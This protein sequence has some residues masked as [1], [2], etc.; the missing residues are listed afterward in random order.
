MNSKKSFLLGVLLCA[1]PLIAENLKIALLEPRVGEGSDSIAGIELSIIQGELR[2]SIVSFEGYDAITRSDINQ[3]MREQNFQR[4]GQVSE[5]QIKQIGELSGADYICVSTITRSNTEFY[6]EAYMIHLE[7]GRISHPAS[8]YGELIAGKIASLYPACKALSQ[9][10]LGQMQHNVIIY[11][12]DNSRVAQTSNSSDQT[13]TFLENQLRNIENI[14]LYHIDPK[15]KID[16]SVDSYYMGVIAIMHQGVEEG[17]YADAF[18]SWEEAYDECPNANKRIYTD[19]EKILIWFY[20]NSKDDV[21]KGR[22]LEKLMELYDKRIFYFGDDKKY[23]IPF[24]IGKKGNTLFKYSLKDEDKL[25]AYLLCKKSVE[26]L[27]ETSNT[28]VIR[29]YFL[30]SLWIYQHCPS[31]KKTFISDCETILHIANLK[32]TIDSNK[33]IQDLIKEINNLH[34]TSD[35]H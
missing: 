25:F 31:H 13:N 34:S 22:Y 1:T 16:I 9:E 30:A 18:E 27:K 12:D 19:G 15:W 26:E 20:E 5:K 33:G 29:S 24:I 2:K 32:S 21:E 6:I 3:I 7:S 28:P 35:I 11:K 10:L 17:K 8:Q 4:T 23:P 14:E